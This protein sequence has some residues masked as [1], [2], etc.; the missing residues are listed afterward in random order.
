MRKTVVTMAVAA[1]AKREGVVVDVFAS[2]PDWRS[3]TSF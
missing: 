3:D 1:N 2:A